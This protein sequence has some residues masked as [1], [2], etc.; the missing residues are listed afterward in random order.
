MSAR[1]KALLFKDE[2]TICAFDKCE[3]CFVVDISHGAIPAARRNRLSAELRDN[4]GRAFKV[5]VGDYI[6]NPNFYAKR[7]FDALAKMAGFVLHDFKKLNSLTGNAAGEAQGKIRRIRAELHEESQR[8]R[9][10][11]RRAQ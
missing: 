4:D 5:R 9:E 8:V 3:F 1:N 10:W 6:R 2:T 7:N 11:Q